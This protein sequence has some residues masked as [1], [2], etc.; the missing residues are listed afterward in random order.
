MSSITIPCRDCTER[1]EAFV[2]EGYRVLGCAPDPA[3]DGMC[4]LQFE[5]PGLGADPAAEAAASAAPGSPVSMAAATAPVTPTQAA[6]IKAIVNP[7]ETSPV[8]GEDGKV[9][10]PR[11]DTG[12][13]S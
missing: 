9:T 7:I 2:R 8:P 5:K 6:T 13:R 10:V 1:R 11:G 3:Q 4:V 12:R